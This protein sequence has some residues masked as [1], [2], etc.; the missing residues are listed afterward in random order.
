MG[1]SI[2]IKKK[3]IQKSTFWYNKVLS[4][5]GI[6]LKSSKEKPL[7]SIKMYFPKKT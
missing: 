5:G 4:I 2:K 7:R 6:V 1:Y 3:N